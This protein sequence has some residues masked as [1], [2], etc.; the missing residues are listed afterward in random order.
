MA[1][2]RAVRDDERRRAGHSGAAATRCGSRSRS[3][4]DGRS[5]LG[6]L[7]ALCKVC[8][9][10]RRLDASVPHIHLYQ[11]SRSMLTG[12]M[13]ARSSAALGSTPRSAAAT[14]HSRFARA[15][16]DGC[17]SEV[18]PATNAPTASHRIGSSPDRES[19][20]TIATLSQ[21]R[22]DPGLLTATVN[23]TPAAGRRSTSSTRLLNNKKLRSQIG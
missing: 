14:K 12:R 17:E 9:H 23:S 7:D 16:Y 10:T 6:T 20:R 15:C 8:S 3:A 4:R 19:R 21:C 18:R 5:G 22:P 11:A 2:D 13:A 1:I